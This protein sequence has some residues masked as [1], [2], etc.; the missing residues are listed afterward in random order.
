MEIG[1]VGSGMVG[2]AVGKLWAKAGHRV[3]FSSRHPTQLDGLVA[4]VGPNAQCGNVDEAIAFGEVLLVSIP[5]NALAA[6]GENYRSQL[7]GKIV[8]E[9]GNPY[10]QRDGNLAG[11][12]LDSRLGTGH[13]SARFLPGTRL[14][15]AYNSVWDRTLVNEAH[16]TPQSLNITRDVV[17]RVGVPLAS[18]D[19]EAMEIVAGL[20]RDS[21]FDP[22]CVGPLSRA[23]EFDIGMPVFNTNMSGIEIRQALGVR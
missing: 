19:A 13:W 21:G 3:F 4:D 10:F 16:R 9:T 12:I 2:G 11:E 1:I 20:V 18:D 8:M 14:V 6:F 22:V 17:M 15:R 23:R 5:Y 7:A